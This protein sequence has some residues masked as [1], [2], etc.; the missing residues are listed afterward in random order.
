MC[1]NQKATCQNVHPLAAL[2]NQGILDTS[3]RYGHPQ[4]PVASS[5]L[6]SPCDRSILFLDMCNCKDPSMYP[7]VALIRSKVVIYNG[8]TYTRR[9][10]I[11]NK[12]KNI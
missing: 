12:H 5:E 10:P 2:P 9:L 3:E 8:N 7:K 1:T 4:D 11:T 6:I